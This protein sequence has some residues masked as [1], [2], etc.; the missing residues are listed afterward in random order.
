MGVMKAYAQYEIPEG[1]TADLLGKI[2]AALDS[3]ALDIAE[4]I[5]ADAQASAAFQDY[6]GTSRESE[7]HKQRYPNARRLRKSIKAK[8]SK[9]EGGGAIVSASAPHA[10]LV[11]YGHVMWIRG[12]NTGKMVPAHPFLRPATQKRVQEAIERFA[13]GIQ[14]GLGE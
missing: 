10:H 14:E 6:T 4:A 5:A 13:K 8:K 2:N 12:K 9:Y 1:F 7:I 11:E 3:G